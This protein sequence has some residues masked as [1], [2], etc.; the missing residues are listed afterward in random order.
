MCPNCINGIVRTLGRDNEEIIQDCPC[1]TQW[2][3]ERVNM[4]P[5]SFS[6]EVFF[7][8]TRIFVR[9]IEGGTH[10]CHQEIQA[11][12]EDAERLVEALNDFGAMPPRQP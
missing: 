12:T 11:A 1:V 5:D 6:V 7:G 3:M 9:D 10:Q 8:P 2:R 4:L